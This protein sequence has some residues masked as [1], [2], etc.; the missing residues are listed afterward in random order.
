MTRLAVGGLVGGLLMLVI[1]A[2]ATWRSRS[3]A[4]GD[5]PSCMSPDKRD[6]SSVHPLHLIFGVLAGAALLAGLDIEAL[7]VYRATSSRALLAQV[8]VVLVVSRG[9]V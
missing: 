6:W 8:A 5:P 7:A 1:D 3:C 9:V 4:E 2:T